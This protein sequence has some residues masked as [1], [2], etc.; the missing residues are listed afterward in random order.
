MVD[1]DQQDDSQE[2]GQQVGYGYPQMRI[3]KA[4]QTAQQNPDQET[5]DRAWQK[6][7]DWVAVLDGMVTGKLSIGSRT[8]TKAPAWATLKV[9]QG[10]FATG[11]LL[12]GGPLQKHELALFAE[13]GCAPHVEGRSHLNRH[14]ISEVGLARLQEV[15][16]EGR[17]RIAVPE[18]GALLVIARLVE[19]GRAADAGTILR[20]IEPWFDKLRFYP[21]FSDKPYSVASRNLAANTTACLDTEVTYRTVEETTQSLEQISPNQQVLAQRETIDVWLPL[22]DR[23]V[24][25]FLE[26][27]E[28]EIPTLR[29]DE[30]GQWVRSPTG[31]FP[32]IGGW[33]CKHYPDGWA[34]A[35]KATIAAFDQQTKLHKLCNRPWS[36]KSSL[37]QLQKYLRICI[38]APEVLTGREVGRIRMI[39]ARYVAKR[40]RPGSSQARAA[41]QQ[42]SVQAS[43]PLFYDR[44]QVA[45]AWIKQFDPDEGL[46]SSV[47]LPDLPLTVRKK[48]ERSV[49][50]T[51]KELV[52]KKIITSGEALARI[53]PQVSGGIQSAGIAD[54]GLQRLYED[55]YQ[56]FRQRRSL[57]LLNLQ[58]QVQ[59][60]ELPWAAEIDRTRS[61]DYAVKASAQQALV[62]IVHL[63]LT[64]FPHAILPN[65]LI[66][67]L[68]AIAQTAQLELP[69][70]EEIA[71]DIFM[72]K[73]SDKFLA[74]AIVAGKA[75]ENSLYATYY[76]IRY[77]RVFD[78]QRGTPNR[79]TSR[80]DWFARLCTMRS[81]TSAFQYGRPANNGMI[82][83]QQQILTT[84][85]LAA[86]MLSDA[87]AA[88][89][90]VAFGD[91]YQQLAQDCFV[92]AVQRLQ[93]NAPT[94][95]AS[96]IH[97]KNAAYAWRQ[98][99]FFLTMRGNT[100]SFLIW[101]KDYL[102]QQPLEFQRRF[103]PALV[104]L[105]LAANGESIN[106]S[107]RIRALGARRLLGWYDQRYWIA[108][109]K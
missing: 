24:D 57:L 87:I 89:I 4:L 53:L 68:S 106:Q 42:Q 100:Q 79:N 104:G 37:G 80:G 59:L 103:Q 29:T 75:L 32:V 105:E 14:F 3:A 102:N 52:E 7:S 51:L 45:I 63:T 96:L 69:L 94:W 10:G 18:E 15:L 84:H 98:M 95:H 35:A 92:W 81:G 21:V 72:G 8:P 12:A 44:A 19:L 33:P 109:D 67:E 49:R 71:A 58:K 36:Q 85:N 38:D 61:S 22:Y 41:R 40:G 1:R 16:R 25:L 55:I 62:D 65:K 101:A 73:F 108:A 66:R 64:S 76:G 74:A 26:T 77:R 9:T 20:S 30:S 28:G 60:K 27:V 83:E 6:I 23:M 91:S 97:L 11:T 56:A 88:Q 46:P 34:A 54:D 2:A 43:G 5:R 17:Y 48:V 39:L 78:M 13:L 99:V 82:I 70:T 47:A 31:K 90:S 50:A 93:M 107:D 86:L